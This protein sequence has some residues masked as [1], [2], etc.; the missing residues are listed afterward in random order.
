VKHLG[1]EL[2]GENLSQPPPR[3]GVAG[4]VIFPQALPSL[5]GAG[6]GYLSSLHKVAAGNLPSSIG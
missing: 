5:G 4:A 6:G 3:G 1:V 2:D